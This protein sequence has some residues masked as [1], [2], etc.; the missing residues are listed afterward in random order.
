[1]SFTREQAEV[2]LEQ[3]MREGRWGEVLAGCRRIADELHDEPSWQLSSV[4]DCGKLDAEQLR[5]EDTGSSLW[6]LGV[7]Y[8]EGRGGVER[9][10][11]EALRCY[12]RAA[13]KGHPLSRWKAG[14][15]IQLGAIVVQ[16]IAR[17]YSLIVEA[18][19]AG[20]SRAWVMAAEAYRKGLGVQQSYRRAAQWYLK[21]NDGRH[22]LIGILS[23]LR[24]KYPL[25]CAPL[26]E[27]EPRWHPLV[28]REIRKAM[29]TT[30]LVCKRKEVPRDLA[31]LIASYVC[32]EGQEWKQLLLKTRGQ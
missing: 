8:F 17:S 9:N 22:N 27:W 18:A 14:Y 7:M 19:E 30:M 3:L 24:R 29:F 20:C 16:D 6:L 23:I 12:I 21:A 13:E 15:L 25:E 28:P 32:T 5:A 26:G 1:M 31:L 10:Y 2:Q 4:L 11:K